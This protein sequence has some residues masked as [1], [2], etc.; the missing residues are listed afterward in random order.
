M[1]A[2][3]RWT[4]GCDVRDAP[5]FDRFVVRVTDD[6]DRDPL[7]DHYRLHADLG[8]Q[9]D[10]RKRWPHGFIVY[11]RFGK[12][13]DGSVWFGSL[14]GHSCILNLRD[15]HRGKTR[16]EILTHAMAWAMGLAEIP[17]E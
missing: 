8:V 14:P 13:R 17:K 15:V 7:V 1:V 10:M 6:I 11:G 2:R 16:R 4:S 9:L 5:D 3:V 12:E